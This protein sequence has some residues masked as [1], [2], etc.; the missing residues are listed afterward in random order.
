M[1]N[2]RNIIPSTN[3]LFAFEAAARLQSFSAAAKELNVSQPAVSAAIRG[4]EENIG[5]QLFHR[6]HRKIE[7]T[8][9]GKQ[10]YK[11]VTAGLEHIFFSAQ[12][13]RLSRS[14]EIVTVSGSTLFIQF[15]ML[16]RLKQFE[17]AFPD[18]E[19]R[20]HSTDR[21]VS[22]HSEGIDISVRLGD[23]KWPEYDVTLFAEEIVY[24]VCSPDY[25]KEKPSITQNTDILNHKLLYVDEPFRIRLNWDDWLWHAGIPKRAI[26]RGIRF[27][28]AEICLQAA[29]N[30]HG[31]ALGWNHMVAPLVKNGTLVALPLYHYSGAN[32][33]YLITPKSPG[34]SA[35]ASAV[36]DW[37]MAE[38]A[39]SL[40]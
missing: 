9:Q 1:Q 27:N 40:G 18:L 14:R 35:Q 39:R 20:L 10:F 21:D 30:G 15:W 5:K 28:D 29:I 26:L 11:D 2:L 13:I 36:R 7:L 32:A 16:P 19:L 38:M 17:N 8:Q 31:I 4:L 25:L 22:L 6:S 33:M 24:P 3:A 23:G 12:D 34:L 37:M